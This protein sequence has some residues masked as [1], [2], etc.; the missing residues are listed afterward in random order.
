MRLFYC[1][2]ALLMVSVAEPVG[3]QTLGSGGL[4]PGPQGP[5]GQS[6]VTIEQ[7]Q[8]MVPQPAN[9]LPP[10]ESASAAIGAQTMRYALEDHV[11][12]RISRNPDCVTGAGGVCTVTFAATMAIP[13][14]Y[15]FARIAA[16]A[17][18]PIP[19]H[20]VA[21]SITTTSAQVKC[22]ATQS[23]LGLGLFPFTT[24]AAGVTVDV[25]VIP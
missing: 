2:L 14:A 23:I 8:S 5:P 19:C 11:H 18:Q 10:S 9:V 16:G 13:K 17:T 6:G 7:V 15:P 4:I 21:G 3:A 20:I 12:P 24:G 1:A 25:F 22:F